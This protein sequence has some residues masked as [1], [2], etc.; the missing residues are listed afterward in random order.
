MELSECQRR[1]LEILAA[2]LGF[3]S[4]ST[5]VVVELANELLDAGI[6]HDWLLPIVDAQPKTQ[7]EVIPSFLAFLDSVNISVPTREKAVWQLLAFYISKII[8]SPDDPFTPLDLMISE[9]YWNYDFHE[10]SN[11]YLGDSHGIQL[12]IGLYWLRTCD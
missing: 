12:L 3:K 4:V 6:Y 8:A 5:E 10:I 7:A 2:R 9:V 11:N 1:N